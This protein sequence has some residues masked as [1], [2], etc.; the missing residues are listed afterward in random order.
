MSFDRYFYDHNLN[1]MLFIYRK[2]LN[3]MKNTT[4]N[5]TLM[6]TVFLYFLE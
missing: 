4:K 1:G 3:D 5:Y 2:C 6:Y